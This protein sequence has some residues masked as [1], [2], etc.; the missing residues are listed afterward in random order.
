VA[1][2]VLVNGGALLNVPVAGLTLTPADREEARRVM[3][4]IRDPASPPL[5]DEVLDDIVA[6]SRSGPTGRMMQDLAGLM[7]HL[8]DGR[9]GEVEV[10]VDA[11]WGASDGLMPLDYARRM[12]DQLPRARLTVLEGCGHIPPSECPERFLAVLREVLA[13]PPVPPPEAPP[14]ED[15]PEDGR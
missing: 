15:L 11:I 6:R 1:R 13:R 8:L 14:R 5:P 10:P 9:L 7:A 2:A 3:A 12:V 4:A